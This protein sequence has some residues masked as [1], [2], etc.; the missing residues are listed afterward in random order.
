M[1]YNVY[2]SQIEQQQSEVL[3]VRIPGELKSRLEKLSRSTARTKSW[4][5]IDAIRTYLEKEEWQV[6]EIQK[7]LEEVERNE[8]ATPEEVEAVFSRW[9]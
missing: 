4:L 9:R 8:V 6:Q 3:T 5:A 1:S 7:G 2:M